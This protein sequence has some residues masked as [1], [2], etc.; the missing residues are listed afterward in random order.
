M[1]QQAATQENKSNLEGSDKPVVLLA[2]SFSESGVQTLEALGCRVILNASLKD[3]AL[4]E[5]IEKTRPR[6][7]VVRSTKVTREMM[8]AMMP[9]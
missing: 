7:V 2:D 6:I 1:S 4:V 5:A 8:D 9:P 3:E